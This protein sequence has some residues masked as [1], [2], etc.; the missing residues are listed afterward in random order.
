MSSW[1]SRGLLSTA[2]PASIPGLE[3]R[4]SPGGLLFVVVILVVVVVV[5]V[6]VV[7]VVGVV[8]FPCH[9][10]GICA[11]SKLY[12]IPWWAMDSLEG[13]LLKHQLQAT[14]VELNVAWL[15]SF[16]RMYTIP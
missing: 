7:A 2:S 4:V 12:N 1:C 11:G 5:V 6:A 3:F 8:V 15:C 13:D 14:P 10:S 16:V 9:C